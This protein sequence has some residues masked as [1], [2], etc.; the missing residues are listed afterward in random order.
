MADRHVRDIAEFCL[1][2]RLRVHSDPFPQFRGQGG[3]ACHQRRAHGAC[4][5]D[6][7]HADPGFQKTHQGDAPGSGSDIQHAKTGARDMAAGDA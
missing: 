2:K 7:V 3:E 6:G 4:G 1:F 5:L